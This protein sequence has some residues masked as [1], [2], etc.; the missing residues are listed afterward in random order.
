[1]V[2]IDPSNISFQ[3]AIRTTEHMVM[4]DLPDHVH[5][6]PSPPGSVLV[7]DLPLKDLDPS[8]HSLKHF[9]DLV[10]DIPAASVDMDNIKAIIR[11]KAWHDLPT[12]M[13]MKERPAIIYASTFLY[14]SPMTMSVC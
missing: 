8:S 14:P 6:G 12:F 3:D 11:D 5:V 4:R 13:Q 9:P 1:M 2:S 7:T 10:I